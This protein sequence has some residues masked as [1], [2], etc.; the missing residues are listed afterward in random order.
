MKSL[1]L[2]IL[3]SATTLFAQ[4][5][6]AVD[7]LSQTSDSKNFRFKISPGAFHIFGRTEYEF[8][9]TQIVVDTSGE[10]ITVAVR[11]LLEFPL[12]AFL[13]GGSIGLGSL[14]EAVSFWNIEIG[15]F[16]NINDPRKKM[17]DSDWLA[18]ENY[19]SETQF[20]YT[21][22]DP[23]MDMIIFNFEGAKE[24]INLSGGGIAILAGFRYQKIEQLEI[25]YEGW[26]RDL[27]SNLTFQPQQLVSGT[28]PALYYEIT[29][30]GPYF[31][32]LTKIN[33]SQSLQLNFKTAVSLV[34]INDFDDH[35]LRGFHTDADG[36]GLGLLSEL[37]LR[38]FSK[39]LFG[40]QQTHIDFL[41]SYDHFSASLTKNFYQYADGGPFEQPQGYSTGG[42]PHDIKSGQF[43]TGIQIGISF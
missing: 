15:I 5:E 40:G 3:V 24:V 30:K 6:T 11:S 42:L 18:L 20:S 37:K 14:E 4:P 34:W 12:D 29:Y 17:K 16:A 28:G 23:Q 21:E 32:A 9:L 39:T 26:F 33:L 41:G 43:K 22:S 25:G 1:F 38:W 10:N 7:D 8:A 13:I 35:L 36:N 27:D 31:G 2:L 19:F